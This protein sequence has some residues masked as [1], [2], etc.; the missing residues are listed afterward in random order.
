MSPRLVKTMADRRWELVQAI[1]T[2]RNAAHNAGL[3]TGT[4]CDTEQAERRVDAAM[5]TIKDIFDGAVKAARRTGGYD[6]AA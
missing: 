1:R 3:L 5:D 4:E 2:L 6:D